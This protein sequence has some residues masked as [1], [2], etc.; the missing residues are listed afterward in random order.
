MRKNVFQPATNVSTKMRGSPI[1][2]PNEALW[3]IFMQFREEPCL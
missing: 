2:L 1:L 3:F